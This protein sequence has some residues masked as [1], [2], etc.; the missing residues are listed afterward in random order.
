MLYSRNMQSKVVEE[1]N[2]PFFNFLKLTFSVALVLNYP[3]DENISVNI[4]LVLFVF[5]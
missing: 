5:I 2:L 3:V 1:N 4:K